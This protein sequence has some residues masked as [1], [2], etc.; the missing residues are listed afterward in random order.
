MSTNIRELLTL[1]SASE[2]HEDMGAVLW[3]KLPI[4]EPPYVGSPLDLGYPALVQ[5]RTS[6][7]QKESALPSLSVS[8]GGWPGY[9]THFS[10]IPSV[11]T[12]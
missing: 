10:P 1:R 11:V 2:W 12:P 5:V 3:W 7:D 4:E 8:I 9:H 6:R